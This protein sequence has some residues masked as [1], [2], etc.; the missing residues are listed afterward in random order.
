M[1]VAEAGALVEPGGWRPRRRETPE[2][3]RPESGAAPRRADGRWVSGPAGPAGSTKARAPPPA[4]SSPAAYATTGPQ[5]ATAS[6]RL[7]CPLAA[8][9][10]HPTSVARTALRPV[11]SRRHTLVSPI[12]RTALE[13]LGTAGVAGS[14]TACRRGA[15]SGR[16][17]AVYWQAQAERSRRRRRPG[18]A[19]CFVGA[20][21]RLGG[22]LEVSGAR[23][24]T[25]RRVLAAQH[26]RADGDRI[27][28]AH[29]AERRASGDPR[30][31]I[32]PPGQ[33]GSCPDRTTQHQRHRVDH[34]VKF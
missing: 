15:A 27:W 7:R 16:K 19:W 12:R 3:L 1:R 4:R 13:R 31:G 21:R 23:A 29:R 6:R 30:R 18:Q 28:P 34:P 26:V 22:P 32:W 11:A 2:E 17:A 25:I 14:P 8:P 10:A 9:S 24:G 5:H 33:P 20:L